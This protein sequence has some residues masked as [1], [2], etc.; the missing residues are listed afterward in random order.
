MI[1]G[2]T[3]AT[4][5]VTFSSFVDGDTVTVNGVVLTGKNSPTTSAQFG[6]GASDT[7]TASNFVKLI[8]GLS[9]NGA[10]PAKVWGIVS[11]TSAAAIA[12]LTALDSGAIGNLF[13]LAIS[14]HGSVGGAN[15]SSGADGTIISLAKGL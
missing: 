9:A 10:P 4:N 14:A 6:I 11:A 3:Q 12:T 8:N 5:T 13:T 2:G 1:S 15:F 7:I